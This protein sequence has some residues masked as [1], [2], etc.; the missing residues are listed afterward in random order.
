[1][2]PGM[3]EAVRSPDLRHVYVVALQ[4]RVSGVAET[5]L[6]YWAVGTSL[7][8][9]QQGRITAIGRSAHRVTGWPQARYA[10]PDLRRRV[11][12]TV[13]DSAACLLK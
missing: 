7:A 8:V 9:D 2:V 12:A 11:A 10:S 13:G 1:M 5:Q 3:A 4:F 6:G